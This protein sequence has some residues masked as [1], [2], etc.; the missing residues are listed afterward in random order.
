[1]KDA[2]QK[3]RGRVLA[4]PQFG[5]ARL[6]ASAGYCPHPSNPSPLTR[7]LSKN[8][9]SSKETNRTK[10]GKSRK[11]HGQEENLSNERREILP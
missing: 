9:N 3:P 4:R 8:Q 2:S 11:V 5:G 1:M 6:S 7:I 10:A